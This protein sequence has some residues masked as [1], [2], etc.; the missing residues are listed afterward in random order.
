MAKVKFIVPEDWP[1]TLEDL[2]PGAFVSGSHPTLLCLKSEYRNEDGRIDA[3]NSAGEFWCG[4]PSEMLWPV[5]IEER[6]E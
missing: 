3:Y 1:C 4:D 6:E 5:S 2:R